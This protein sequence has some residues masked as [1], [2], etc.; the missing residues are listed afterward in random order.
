M[1]IIK[2]PGPD[3]PI[4]LAAPP[5]RMRARYQGHVI[6]DSEN[7]LLLAE[8][9]YPPVCY[10][11]R[12]DVAMEFFARSARGTHCPYKG[13]ASY[14]T[15]TMDGTIGENAAWSYEEPYPAVAAIAGRIAFYADQIEVYAAADASPS[16]SPD[17]VILHTD[18]G[19]GT[20]Q[21]DH[22]RPNTEEPS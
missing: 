22:W 5:G 19:A 7:A 4:T 21:R 8:A 10:F 11:P 6:A 15:V 13:D 18:D 12:E 2:T 3:H 14:F 9:D 20:S 16:P 1:D 17:D